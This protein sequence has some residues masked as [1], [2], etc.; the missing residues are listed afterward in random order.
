MI[1]DQ[2][3]LDQITKKVI[4]RGFEPT[5]LGFYKNGNELTEIESQK[6]YRRVTILNEYVQNLTETGLNYTNCNTFLKDVQK[7]ETRIRDRDAKSEKIWEFLKNS[8][9]TQ[10][11][12]PLKSIGFAWGSSFYMGD[13]YQNLTPLVQNGKSDKLGRPILTEFENFETMQNVRSEKNS[14]L[15][16][17]DAEWVGEPRYILSWQFSCIVRGY[18]YEYVFLRTTDELLSLDIALA[19]ILDDVNC[20]AYDSSKYVFHEACVGFNGAGQPLWER[21]VGRGDMILDSGTI[22]PLFENLDGK[23]EPASYTIDDGHDN[24]RLDKFAKADERSW[25]WSRRK[26]EFP[27]KFDVTLVCH[28]GKVD[29][30]TLKVTNEYDNYLRYVSDIQGGAISLNPLSRIVKSRRKGYA[31]NSYVYPLTLNFRD[32]MGQAPAGKKSLADLGDA[33]RIPK[34]SDGKINKERMDLV[35]KSHSKLYFEYASRDA[36]VTVLYASAIYGYNREMAVTLT[37]ATAKAMRESMKKYLNVSSDEEFDKK[38]RGIE[39]VKKGL[40]KDLVKPGFLTAT[41]KQA[42][43]QEIRDILMY[44]SEAYHGGLNA[45]SE[46]GW[47]EGLTND[48]DLQNAYPTAMVLVPDIDWEDPVLTELVRVPVTLKHFRDSRL[49]SGFNPMLPMF[50]RITFEFPEDVLYPCIPVNVEGRL[51]FPRT[52][53]GL[54]VVYATGPEI[55]L[56]L[57]LGATIH[58]ER[59]WVL[60]PR[61]NDDGS[62]SRSLGHA[63][64]RLVED[65]RVAKQMF[66]TKSLEELIFKTMVNSGYGKNAQNVVDKTTWDAY[67]QEMTQL[68]D[69]AITN[70]VSAS[71]TTSYVRA[72]LLATMNEAHSK[73][74]RV[75]S[76]TTDGF[77][78]NIPSVEELEQYSLLGFNDLTRLAR[79]FL[80]DGQDESIW[81]IKHSQNELLNLTTRGNMAPTLGGVCAHNSTKSPYSSGSL[82]DRLWFIDKSLTRESGLVYRDKVWTTFKDLSKG[83]NFKVVDVERCVS[84]DF[85]MKRKPKRDSFYTVKPVIDGKVYETANFETVPFESVEEARLYEQKKKICD[86]LRT[87]Q[88]WAMFW[89]KIDTNASGK[90]VRKKDGL[91]WSKLMSCVMGARRGLWTID[92]LND[93]ST[94]VQEKCDWINSFGLSPKQFK[95]SDWKN[96]RRADRQAN[97]LGKL[98]ISDFLT[99]LGAHDFQI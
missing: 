63:V 74:N 3:Q 54:D 60:T 58:C 87:E 29:L 96:A 90:Q 14:F 75:Y 89:T 56:A 57:Q 33:V 59:G 2:K 48:F 37:S 23:W 94:T 21:Y 6:C 1:L 45:S 38:Y 28:T 72:L 20:T 9:A 69:S 34:L 67:N 31:S 5:Q 62:E 11:R 81:E 40:V 66:G 92:E 51:I 97:M 71:L 36:T 93:T 32:T 55:F 30:S 99:I 25:K 83:A 53:K 73:G 7:C 78:A 61:Y 98:Y 10:N 15:I 39:K 41:N 70:P 65:R 46:I 22:H 49:K 77:I 18:L 47:F 64:K 85:D 95:P 19:K 35:L 76:V 50:G 88:D 43:T 4:K 13:P 68:G 27:R 79:R 52:S 12:K 80:T 42:T 16:G 86:V 84:M 8:Q 91:E 17:F 44:A 24:G 26:I 82:E